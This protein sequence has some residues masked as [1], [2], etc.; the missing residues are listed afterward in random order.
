MITKC[1]VVTGKFCRQRKE[2]VGKASAAID[3]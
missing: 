3:C 1:T 2:G